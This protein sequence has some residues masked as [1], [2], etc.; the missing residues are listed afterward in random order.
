MDSPKVTDPIRYGTLFKT[1]IL[2]FQIPNSVVELAP[3]H[4]NFLLKPDPL[5]D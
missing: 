1:Q 2:W 3:S 5:W 4:K